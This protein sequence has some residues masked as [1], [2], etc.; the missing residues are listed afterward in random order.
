MDGQGHF[1][2]SGFEYDQERTAYLNS[3]ISKGFDSK[4]KKFLTG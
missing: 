4:T 1:T 2:T 3:L